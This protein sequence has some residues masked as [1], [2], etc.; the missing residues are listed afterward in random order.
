MG[1]ALPAAI[2]AYHANPNSAIL[3][4]DGDGSLLMNLGELFTIG[5]YQLPIKVLM[6]NNHGDGMVRNIQDFLYKGKHVATQKETEVNFSKIAQELGF[7]FHA[8]VQDRDQ[9]QPG[10]EKLMAASGPSFLEVVCDNNEILYP[11]IPTGQGYK[12]MVLGPYIDRD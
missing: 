3:A 6:L 12:D 5:R 11:R 1:F 4:I 9:L 2:G 7:L 8:R 10:L